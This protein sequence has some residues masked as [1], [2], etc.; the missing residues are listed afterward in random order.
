MVNK[1]P[2]D[3]FKIPALSASGINSFYKSPLHYW[4]ESPFNPNKI[5]R[6]ST[7]AMLLGKVA[8]K[9]ILEYD[10]FNDEFAVAPKCDK[11]T[12]L[13]KETFAAFEAG[14]FGKVIVSDD[15]YAHAKEM[16]EALNRNNAVME[17]LS[18]G[19][20][21]LPLLWNNGHIQCKGKID[22]YRK[23]LI[24]DYKTTEDA[25]ENGFSKSIASWGYHR[26]DAWYMDGVEAV[27]RERPRGFIFI[28]Q[29]KEYPDNI[30][31]YSLF[32]Q[33]RDIGKIE[34]EKASIE[35]AERIESGN[36]KSYP[37]MIMTVGL[38]AYYKR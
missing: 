29:E 12:T 8:H 15:V 36:W 34:N 5:T 7:P 4:R 25:S 26:Q 38:P 27:Y 37:E 23:G 24:I 28:V 32:D 18:Q 2:D 20:S 10:T 21:E 22:R 31:I 17:L 16:H 11:R 3:Y 9:L 14:N 19:E 6:Q 35:I 1:Q 13:G 30:G 33:D